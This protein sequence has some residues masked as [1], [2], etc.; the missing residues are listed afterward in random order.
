[1]NISPSVK[2]SR[3]FF[4]V[5]IIA[6]G[7]QHFIFKDFITGRPPKWPEWL[8]GQ[9]VIAYLSGIILIA[10]GLAI[11]TN[12]RVKLVLLITGSMIL[13][14]AGMRNLTGLI[15]TLD[16]GI[17]LTT[18]NKALTLGFGA[19][20]VAATFGNENKTET[21]VD[22]WTDRLAPVSRYTIGFFLF[23]SGVQHFLFA[24]FVKFLIPAWIPGATFWVYFSGVALIAGGLGILTNIKGKFAAALSGWMIFIWLFVLHIPRAVTA[25]T[26]A[27]N[28]WIGVFEA[29]AVS[30]LLFILSERNGKLNT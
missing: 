21:V 26:G 13:L 30:G 29:L 3:V 1:M 4:A 9:F 16:Y 28:E 22:K 12:K 17:L 23:A 20:L 7:V 19:F 2:V 18:T 6:L 27:G 14:W 5:A 11:L 10:A 15:T 25:T 24:D 8:P